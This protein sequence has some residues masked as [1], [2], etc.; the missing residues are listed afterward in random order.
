MVKRRIHVVIVAAG[1]GSRFGSDIPKQ[2]HRLPSTGRTVL[3][4]AINVFRRTLP[5]ADITVVVSKGMEHFV[6]D[7]DV[8]VVFGGA[9][10]FH[11]VFNAVSSLETGPD[12]I[13]LIHDGARPLVD[14]GTIDSVVEALESHKAVVPVVA[15]TDSLRHVES[16]GTTRIVD[17]ADF[18]AVQTPQGFHAR[19]LCQAYSTEYRQG[20]TDDASVVEAAGITVATVD[21]N[22]DNIKITNPADLAM[23]DAILK[24]LQH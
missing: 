6:T 13:I 5:E 16:D 14:A 3:D 7:N 12:D 2:F 9:T 10:R 17:R 19:T 4:T 24:N 1:T 15:V 23:A 21:G 20:F 18:R 11:S 8:A 22:P